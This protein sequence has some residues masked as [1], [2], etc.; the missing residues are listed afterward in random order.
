MAEPREKQGSPGVACSPEQ[1]CILLLPPGRS[2]PAALV[3]GLARRQVH[4]IAVPDAPGVMEQ[5]A[6]GDTRIIILAHPGHI[7]CC[8]ELQAALSQYHP[9]ATVWHYEAEAGTSPSLKRLGLQRPALRRG[10]GQEEVLDAEVDEESTQGSRF[11]LEGPLLT[12]E[13]LSMLMGDD[14]DAM[15]APPAAKPEDSRWNRS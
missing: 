12:P 1:R 5:M 9:S 7:E 6:A 8:N 2:W 10:P 11:N 3:Q 14:P 4:T 15:A 13:E